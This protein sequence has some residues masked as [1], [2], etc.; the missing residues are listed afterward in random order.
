MV[1]FNLI[2]GDDILDRIGDDFVRMYDDGES[3]VKI[4]ETLNITR[5]QFQNLKQRLIRR[6]LIKNVRN[7]G[8][9]RKRTLIRENKS[10]PKNYFYSRQYKGYFVRKKEKYYTCFKKEEDAKKFVE[11]MRECDWDFNRRYE[12]K[13][14]VLNEK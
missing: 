9:G 6:G 1:T 3:I 2:E 7:K 13:R 5:A 4:C 8:A 14:K 10:N 12:L 11:L